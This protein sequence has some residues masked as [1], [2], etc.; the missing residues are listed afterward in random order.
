MDNIMN[1]FYFHYWFS[2]R[3]GQKLVMFLTKKCFCWIIFVIGFRIAASCCIANCSTNFCSFLRIFNS[4]IFLGNTTILTRLWNAQESAF[5]RC[6]SLYKRGKKDCDLYCWTIP[7]LCFK[8][9]KLT[10]LAATF[11]WIFITA[12]STDGLVP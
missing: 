10:F 6:R 3:L 11:S 5:Q 9:A 12:S 2:G 8:K 1:L 7:I 4:F